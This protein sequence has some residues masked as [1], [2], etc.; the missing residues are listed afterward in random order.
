MSLSSI[1]MA[2]GWEGGR[3]GEGRGRNVKKAKEVIRNPLCGKKRLK[4][5]LLSPS[6]HRDSGLADIVA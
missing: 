4:G 2:H 3:G 6:L 1:V 5:D